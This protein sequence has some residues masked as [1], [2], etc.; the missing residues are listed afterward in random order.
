MSSIIQDRAINIDWYRWHKS[1][2]KWHYSTWKSL[3][4]LHDVSGHINTICPF[5]YLSLYI[6]FISLYLWCVSKFS[7]QKFKVPKKSPLLRS[8]FRNYVIWYNSKFNVNLFKDLT[9]YRLTVQ[10]YNPYNGLSVHSN[11]SIFV[12]YW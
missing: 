3:K 10:W 7:V 12:L 4:K 5:I 9:A 2:S 11:W 1:G 8:L 6:L